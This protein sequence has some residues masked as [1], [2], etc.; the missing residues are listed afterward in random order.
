MNRKTL[1]T[2][3]A[4]ALAAATALGSFAVGSASAG[5]TLSPKFDLELLDAA[6]N[7]RAI[8][9]F[10]HDV[11]AQTLRRL[12]NAGITR[13]VR[14]D[15]IDAVGVVGSTEAYEAIARWNDVRFVDADSPVRFENHVAKK[16]T[17]VDKVRKGA[18]KVG[19]YNGKGI[20]VAI[21]DTGIESTHQDLDD[22]VVKHV[23]FEPA[24][25][26]DMINDGVYSDQVAEAT[27]N[28]ID[29]YGHGTHVAGIVAGT[30][31]AADGDQDMS[32]VAPGATLANFKIA[33]VQQ[34]VDCTLPCDI[35][36]E[37][38]ALVAY[39]YAIE[40]RNDK[41]YP[42]GIRV[43]NNSWSTYEVDSEVEPISLIVQAAAKKG[44]I[45]VFAAGNDGPGKNTVAKGPNSLES[46]ITVAAACKSEDSCG[47][48][49]IADF[50][51][52][53]PQVDI[54]APGDNI[55]SALARAS[56]FG[57]IGSHSPPG[58]PAD[59]VDYVGLSGTSMAAPHV[60]GIVA[61]MLDANPKLTRAQVEKI[62]IKTAVDRGDKGFDTS[63][64]FGMVD[65]YA[66]VNKAEALR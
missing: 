27:G 30:G 23:N 21:I 24:W 34:G 31:E 58:G 16:D 62:L 49:K 5:T 20:T 45:S 50:S 37:M 35:G 26:F 12:A 11:T 3:I 64:G 2:S 25:F 7:G 1:R 66:A 36:W 51:S 52:R 22:R 38:N 47:K 8:I 53:G 42:G 39:E 60:A 65:A 19:K 54:A 28:P 44:I 41:I 46:V 4:C 29:S 61:L 63:W 48:G 33:D 18:G 32:G 57:P 15:T 13:A 9:G 17:G 56:A 55:Y 59:A 14:V 40:H 43:I 10:D 6:S